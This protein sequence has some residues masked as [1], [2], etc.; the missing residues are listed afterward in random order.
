MSLFDMECW[1]VM[2]ICLGRLEMAD[3]I[4]WKIVKEKKNILFEFI[5]NN[6]TILKA[7][8][9]MAAV[10]ITHLYLCSIAC[11]LWTIFNLLPNKFQNTQLK[12]RSQNKQSVQLHSLWLTFCQADISWYHFDPFRNRASHPF[13]K[14]KNLFQ[15]IFK[16]FYKKIV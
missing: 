10:F 14:K 15:G 11:L 6:V 5:C 4:N 8:R 7:M 16:I 9:Q 12:Y 3:W 1:W 13:L 2:K